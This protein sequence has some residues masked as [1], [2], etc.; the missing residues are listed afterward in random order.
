MN[1]KE[2]LKKP[3]EIITE[4]NILD[5]IVLPDQPISKLVEMIKVKSS[6][7]EEFLIVCTNEEYVVNAVITSKEVIN[8]L[9]RIVDVSDLKSSRI[10]ALTLENTFPPKFIVHKGTA[11]VEQVL[12]IMNSGITDVVIVIDEQQK[13]AGKIRRSRLKERLQMLLS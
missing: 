6:K 2:L 3:V 11:T 8:L 10:R 12:S 5:D 9:N 1:L 4:N 13:Y 7:S